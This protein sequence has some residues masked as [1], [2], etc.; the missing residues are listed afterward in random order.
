[1]DEN[2]EQ[3]TDVGAHSTLDPPRTLSD[4]NS[5]L[6]SIQFDAN[7]Q[8]N[9][10]A[11]EVASIGIGG[12]FR[13]HANTSE[14]VGG[15]IASNGT[16]DIGGTDAN[17]GGDSDR[18]GTSSTRQSP[19]QGSMYDY[20]HNAQNH[21]DNADRFV[22]VGGN[23]NAET[24]I[25][26]KNESRRTA[27]VSAD[28]GVDP[29]ADND[30]NS[31]ADAADAD[32]SHRSAADISTGEATSQQS[33]AVA[34]A[35]TEAKPEKPRSTNTD[36]NDGKGN[37]TGQPHE[38]ET[39]FQWKLHSMLNDM[40]GTSNASIVSW[41]DDGKAFRIYQRKPF[42]KTISPQYF[43]Y[44]KFKSFQRQLYLYDFA[45]VFKGDNEGAYHHKDFL[46]DERH[47]CGLIVRKDNRKATAQL[48]KAVAEAG[49]SGLS[50]IGFPMRNPA[51]PG[52]SMDQSFTSHQI[53]PQ[54][55]PPTFFPIPA[56]P[57]ALR[58]VPNISNE[59]NLAPTTSPF[60]SR[61]AFP[62]LP[63]LS[64]VTPSLWPSVA[65]SANLGTISQVQTLSPGRS[66]FESRQAATADQELFRTIIAWVGNDGSALA[67]LRE[68]IDLTSFNDQLPAVCI[69]DFA[70][71]IIG[72]F[73]SSSP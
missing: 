5:L 72:L 53:Q 49:R 23:D 27:G 55:S 35:G 45:R 46:R 24:E 59:A 28:A 37:R 68:I 62:Q 20:G 17:S 70:D 2:D 63:R 12:A 32:I 64:R 13:D 29:G 26:I 18:L 10:S 43:K 58:Y 48:K 6:G 51:L 39:Q 4:T 33:T 15:G 1:M 11:V 42:M 9:A 30:A 36:L 7:H 21:E 60:T 61:V 14:N 25:E 57:S 44:T 19:N 34:T 73:G 50:P 65:E 3:E 38:A 40:Q 67:P 16:S 41:T 8:D 31:N 56:S 69:L 66:I 47:R 71:E 22:C 54:Q 52:P